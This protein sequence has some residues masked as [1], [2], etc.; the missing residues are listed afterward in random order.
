MSHKQPYRIRRRA[1]N[2]FAKSLAN[3]PRRSERFDNLNTVPK[4]PKKQ[5]S[6]HAEVPAA[7]DSSE[8][9]AAKKPAAAKR[10]GS[11][12]RAAKSLKTAGSKI[13]AKKNS[14]PRSSSSKKT[15][16]EASQTS[17]SV[18]EPS[19]SEI[20]LRAYFLAEKR[21]QHGLAGDSAHDWLEA[22][23]QLLEEAAQ[24]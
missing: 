23:R 4:T 14:S 21:L 11:A 17:A 18:A 16:A 22:K 24:R 8:V 20:Q 19:D 10:S 13:G 9:S 7:A 12:R 5:T 6:N 2:R 15:S 3:E 1:R